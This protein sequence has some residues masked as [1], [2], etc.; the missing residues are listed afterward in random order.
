MRRRRRQ[1]ALIKLAIAGILGILLI[2]AAVVLFGRLKKEKTPED[3]EAAGTVQEVPSTHGKGGR[4]EAEEEA[5]PEEPEEEEEEPRTYSY[6]PSENIQHLGGEL[7][8]SNAIFVDLENRTILAG[9]EEKTRIVPASMTKVLTL[10][11]AAEH[12]NLPEDLDETYTVTAEAIDYCFKNGCSCAGFE[13]NEVVTVR[14]LLHGTVLPSGGE[15]AMGLALYVSGSQEA[16]VE[17]MNEKLAELGLSESAHFTNCVG[18]YE[19]D[20][21]CT[22]YDLAVMMEA[23]LDND[24]C[25]EVLSARTYLTSETEQ[26]PEGLLLSNWFLRRIEDKDTG[27][28]VS[29]G[30]TGYVDKSGFCAVSYG[31]DRGTGSY[32]CVT[33]DA[34]GN[35]K[36]I[37]DHVY[38]YQNFSHTTE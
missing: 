26:H 33:A 22:V 16:F 1:R 13:K 34:S 18:I 35:W 5:E 4:M 7:N 32:I 27:G 24:L 21:Y 23:A 2:A 17:L 37:N 31:T 25:R 11:V 38:L 29:A 20:H 3:A 10:L 30:K 8:S 6:E 28:K 36:C 14:D 19:D 9:K 12:L 15:A